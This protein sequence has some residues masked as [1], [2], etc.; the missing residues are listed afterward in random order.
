MILFVMSDFFAKILHLL[1]H[2]F[3]KKQRSENFASYVQVVRLAWFKGG[4][5]EGVN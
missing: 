3:A 5:D 1:I 4:M 2:S